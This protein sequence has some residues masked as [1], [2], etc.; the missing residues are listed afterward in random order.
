M[1]AANIVLVDGSPAQVYYPMACGSCGQGIYP[2]Q[3]K[4]SE[5]WSD[6]F[7]RDEDRWK[8]NKSLL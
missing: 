5:H 2:G 3:L 1:T 6:W 7:I 4:Q 8:Q